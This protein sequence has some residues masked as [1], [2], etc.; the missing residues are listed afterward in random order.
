MLTE[1]DKQAAEKHLS[2]YSFYKYA[3]EIDQKLMVQVYMA[4]I[5]HAREAQWIPVS[6]RLPGNG[7]IV[8]CIGDGDFAV[9][10]IYEDAFIRFANPIPQDRLM[11]VEYTAITHWMR[12][13]EPPKTK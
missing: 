2:K 6:E 13:P 4:G 3:P 8:L 9:M 12:L 11:V 10:S 5:K 7:D 1:Q